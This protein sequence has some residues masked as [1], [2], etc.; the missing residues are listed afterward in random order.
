SHPALGRLLLGTFSIGV[1][2][3]I[4]FLRMMGD[5]S[6]EAVQGDQAKVDADAWV[7]YGGTSSRN[8]ANTAV[9][10]LPVEWTINSRDPKKNSKNVRW[11]A[12]LGSKS[13]GGPIVAGGKVFIGTNNQKPRE[14]SIVENGKTVDLVDPKTGKPLDKGIL[15]CFDEKTGAF[16]W[17]T[18][19]HKLP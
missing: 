17:Q 19:F 6:A 9:K 5:N 16:N 7:M 2:G 4:I 11:V 1:F 13:Y 12:E 10:G 18:V 8:M 14:K 3:L 15:M